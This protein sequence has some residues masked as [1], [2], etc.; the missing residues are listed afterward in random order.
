MEATRMSENEDGPT[1]PL[2]SVGEVCGCGQ[3]MLPP[4]TEEIHG[5]ILHR[6]GVP[7]FYVVP[8]GDRNGW[9]T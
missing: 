9:P 4:N 7:C 5:N 3:V 8:T 1:V 2:E 6:I